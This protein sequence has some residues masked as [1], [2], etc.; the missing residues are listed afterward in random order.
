MRICEEFAFK[1]DTYHYSCF[2]FDLFLFLSNEK[3][4]NKNEFKLIGITCISI[5]AKIEEVQIPKLL[6]YAESI[7]DCNYKIVDIINTEKKI[8]GALGWK[9]IP[10]T[11]SSW[12]N[13]YTCQWDLFVHS[14]GNIKEKLLLF[15]DDDN[16]LFFKR[17]NEISY[18]NYRRLYQIIDLIILDY[19]SYKYEI[20]YLI[21]ACFLISICLHYN[22]EYDT[23]E[24]ILKNKKT[25]KILKKDKNEKG[26]VLLE[27]YSQF[28]E[29]SFDYS[30]EDKKLI[31]CINFVYKFIN[32][33]FSY[34]MP[35]IFQVEQDNIN[36]YSYEDFISYQTTC[37]N[38]LPFFKEINKKEFK[39]FKNKKSVKINKNLPINKKGR[40][41]Q[42]SLGKQSTLKTRKSFSSR[43]SSL[44]KDNSKNKISNL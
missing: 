11:I 44:T 19:H 27:I 3:I 39:K 22:L 18:Y 1:R 16:I 29:Q 42:S 5:S 9:L 38:I 12:L 34:D 26:T 4:K 32:F 8:C 36:D 13:W 21:A 31:E 25:T 20:R 28:I 43:K 35:L 14:I 10:M 15:T 23:K 30:F 24:K 17:Q 41:S 6:E 37:E 40:Q 33:K 2:Y 7:N